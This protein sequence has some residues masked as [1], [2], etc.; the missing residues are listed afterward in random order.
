VVLPVVFAEASTI[1]LDLISQIE[2]DA[3]IALGQAEG[4]SAINLERVAINLADARIPDNA[5]VQL[6]D[7]TIADD[8]PFAYESTLPLR[9][10]QASL[11]A[12]GIASTI[13]LSAGAFLCNHVFYSVRHAVAKGMV[14]TA[15]RSGFIHLPL[16]PE[17]HSEFPGLPTMELQD[18]I[19]AIRTALGILAQS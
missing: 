12:E 8:G 15:L 9:A 16:L 14:R 1:T 7:Q 2:P 18:Q 19:R 10:M 17:Q 3:V 5:G 6:S 11:E 13:S 4:R